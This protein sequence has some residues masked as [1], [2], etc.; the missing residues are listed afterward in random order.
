MR[1]YRLDAADGLPGAFRISLRPD[2]RG[3]WH[4]LATWEGRGV[5]GLWLEDRQGK[6]LMRKVGAS[7]LRLDARIEPP[8]GKR[9]E[10]LILRFAPTTTRGA[11]SGVL[12]VHPP[13]IVR[14]EQGAALDAAGPAR[15][16]AFGDCLL[17]GVGDGAA[18]R[19]LVELAAA[20][21]EAD[22]PSRAWALGR[23]RSLRGLLAEGLAPRRL[24]QRLDESWERLH[25]DPPPA[26]PIGRAWRALLASVE[27]LARRQSVKKDSRVGARLGRLGTLL[28]CLEAPAD[29]GASP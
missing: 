2:Q 18:D 20:L 3:E 19:A 26:E 27:D 22:E 25:L 16:P 4:F 12:E 24:R 14:S 15:P 5:A 8:S 28:G 17:E 10:K 21:A 1:R 13:I 6:T 23:A 29:K 9:A 11:L 7:P